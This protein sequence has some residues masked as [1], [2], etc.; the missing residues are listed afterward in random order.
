MNAQSNAKTKR[1]ATTSLILGI[2]SFG[3]FL[4]TC[5]ILSWIKLSPFNET[6]AILLVSLALILVL[7]SLILGIPG[8]VTGFVA[9]IRIRKQGDGNKIMPT[10]ILGLVLSGFGI[11]VFLVYLAYIVLLSPPHPPP[12]EITPFS[13]I[14][15][16]P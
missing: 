14:P 5:L 4:F 15:L 8:L 13:P 1:L 2:L 3:L 6:K 10:T 7:G 12:V 9:L 11:A 16:T